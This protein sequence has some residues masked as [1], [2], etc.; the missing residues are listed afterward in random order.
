MRTASRFPASTRK[1]SSWPVC[2]LLSCAVLAGPHRLPAQR[3][4]SNDEVVKMVQAHLNTTIIVTQIQNS[5]GNYCLNAD[6]LIK[7][8]SLGVPDEVISAMQA[9]MQ[10]QPRQGTS[11]RS[12]AGSVKSDG[13]GESETGQFAVRDW[14]A[15]DRNVDEGY[16]WAATSFIPVNDRGHKGTAEVVATCPRTPEPRRQLLYRIYYTSQDGPVGFVHQSQGQTIEPTCTVAPV[17]IAGVEVTA[18]GCQ[19]VPVDHP[20]YVPLEISIDSRYASLAS[21]SPHGNELIVDFEGSENGVGG[22]LGEAVGAHDIAVR[23][24]L[25]NG[26]TPVI[27]IRPQAPGF[28]H[29]LDICDFSP[30]D[31]GRRPVVA[32]NPPAS[33]GLAGDSP[34]P[35]PAAGANSPPDNSSQWIVLDSN[36]AEGLLMTRTYPVYPPIA[37]A[38]GVSGTVV[39]KATISKTGAVEN[40]APVSG[41]PMLIQAAVNTVKSWRYRPYLVNNAPVEVETTVNVVFTLGAAAH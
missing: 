16:E 41:P 36:A 32:A 2:L 17:P 20:N 8:Q 37:K 35:F 10:A 25:T 1:N 9:R 12:S 24:P 22:S 30:K 19:Y 18:G 5:P 26:D 28:D 39:L 7:L 21:E 15:A 4:C 33:P 38:A 13:G 27:D 3:P 14:K 34:P 23:L 31:L 11:G 29:F 6:S 40:V